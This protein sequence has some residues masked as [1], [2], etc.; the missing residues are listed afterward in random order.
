[1][2]LGITPIEL[3]AW[4]LPHNLLKGSA[5][6]PS[7][8]SFLH[9]KHHRKTQEPAVFL[10]ILSHS[11]LDHIH[12]F[13]LTS[14]MCTGF[15]FYFL[16]IYLNIL[17][18]FYLFFLLFWKDIYPCSTFLIPLYTVWS[19]VF[20]L[21]Q[22]PPPLHLS[23]N[24][25]CKEKAMAIHSSTLAWKIPWAEEPGGLQ[26]KGSLR[27]GHNWATSLS[28]FTFIHWRRKWQPTPVFLPGESQGWG[29]LMGCC[30]WGC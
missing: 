11:P 6:F 9:R 20:L 25:R 10:L 27:V 13:F 16:N 3:I 18:T 14:Y 17:D 15:F 1:M 29:S 12:S 21:T 28:L 19:L 30:L 26:S 8:A 5:V 24:S 22:Q 4:F 2:S 23:S 7:N